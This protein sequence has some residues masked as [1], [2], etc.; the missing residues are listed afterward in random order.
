MSLC[1]DVLWCWVWF[2]LESHLLCSSVRYPRALPIAK[3]DICPIYRATNGRE[4]PHWMC[5][6]TGKPI[7]DWSY[8]RCEILLVDP[9][10]PLRWCPAMGLSTWLWCVTDLTLP[11]GSTAH[12]PSCCANGCS[13]RL[14][15]LLSSSCWT[16][17]TESPLPRAVNSNLVTSSGGC[18]TW[19]CLIVIINI[20]SS[21]VLDL[22]FADGNLPWLQLILSSL[23]QCSLCFLIFSSALTARRMRSTALNPCRELGMG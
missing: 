12:P 14:G 11:S 2:V 4:R 1:S 16:G 9:V 8:R 17:L 7:Q 6:T 20:F 13:R 19:L 22:S 15:F 23:P 21:C 3:L 18:C 5:T 10:T